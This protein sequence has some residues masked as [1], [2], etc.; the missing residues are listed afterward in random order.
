VNK[1]TIIKKTRLSPTENVSVS[2]QPNPFILKILKKRKP[3]TNVKKKTPRTCLATI[4]FSATEAR[5][6][7]NDAKLMINGTAGLRLA[8]FSEFIGLLPLVLNVVKGIMLFLISL[9]YIY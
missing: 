2:T 8:G 3:G 6:P 9:S 4:T 1:P 5:N 7:A